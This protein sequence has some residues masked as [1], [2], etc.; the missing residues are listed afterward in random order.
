MV[1]LVKKVLGVQEQFHGD[2]EQQSAQWAVIINNSAL[3]I[4]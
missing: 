4:N 3:Q 1:V 2:H